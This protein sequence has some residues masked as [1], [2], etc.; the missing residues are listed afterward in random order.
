VATLGVTP[1]WISPWAKYPHTE[2]SHQ[3]TAGKSDGAAVRGLRP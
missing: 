1:K 3:L 2:H